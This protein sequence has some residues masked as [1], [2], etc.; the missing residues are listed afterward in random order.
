MTEIESEPGTGLLERLQRFLW[1]IGGIIILAFA[2][3]TLLGLMLPELTRGV[4][5]SWWS[6]FLWLWLRKP[7][8]G[9]APTGTAEISNGVQSTARQSSRPPSGLEM[10]KRWTW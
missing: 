10:S 4:L 1:D 8:A 9:S 5:L 3:M 7:A 2:L 6:E